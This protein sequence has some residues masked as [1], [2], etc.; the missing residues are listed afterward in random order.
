[1]DFNSQ[2]S[3]LNSVSRLAFFQ[4]F[5][6]FAAARCWGAL[7]EWWA[8]AVES[9]LKRLRIEGSMWIDL[10]WRYKKYFTGECGGQTGDAFKHAQ[11][12]QHRWRR[13]HGAVRQILAKTG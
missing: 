4:P 1:M 6:V 8:P 12:H 2:F 10:V 5:A 7:S 13:G 9:I 3:I 11:E